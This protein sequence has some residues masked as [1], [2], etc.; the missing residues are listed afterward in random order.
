MIVI[1]VLVQLLSFDNTKVKCCYGQPVSNP[2]AKKSSHFVIVLPSTGELSLMTAITALYFRTHS[3]SFISSSFS[4]SFEVNS[5][6]FT[7]FYSAWSKQSQ[8]MTQI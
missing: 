8:M 1:I 4:S 3:M 5:S 2:V 7:Y 6:K